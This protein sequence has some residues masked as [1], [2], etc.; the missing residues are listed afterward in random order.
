MCLAAHQHMSKCNTLPIQRSFIPPRFLPH[1]RSRRLQ[2]QLQLRR[3]QFWL[4]LS[5]H[6][7]CGSSWTPA[8]SISI[9][10]GTA[11][12]TCVMALPIAERR[13]RHNSTPTH[14]ADLMS[15]HTCMF[16]SALTC[17][18]A[19]P[20][21]LANLSNLRARTFLNLEL[22]CPGL[23]LLAYAAA[24]GTSFTIFQTVSRSSSTSCKHLLASWQTVS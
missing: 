8:R 5:S 18:M 3:C 11:F 19:L 9:T 6:C 23:P 4:H 22:L 21:L 24:P 2:C 13:Q 14:Q 7:C 17:L 1:R 10:A 16:G 20:L 12:G 15:I